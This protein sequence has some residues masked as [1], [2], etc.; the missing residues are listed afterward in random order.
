MREALERYKIRGGSMESYKKKAGALLPLDG[1]Q[2][3]HNDFELSLSTSNSK[4]ML[5][6]VKLVI[7]QVFTSNQM[8]GKWPMF[9]E[10]SFFSKSSLRK[11]F[12]TDF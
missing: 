12:S 8:R 11:M 7:Y 9:I 5:I 6:F 3:Y 2:Y 10:F 1:P 4:E